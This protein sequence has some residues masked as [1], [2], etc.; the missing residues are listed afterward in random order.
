MSLSSSQLFLTK[1]CFFK[2]VVYMGQIGCRKNVRG[3]LMRQPRGVLFVWCGTKGQHGKAAERPIP[4][5]YPRT[6]VVESPMS[7]TNGAIYSLWMVGKGGMV[8]LPTLL[9]Y[10]DVFSAKEVFGTVLLRLIQCS[11]GTAKKSLTTIVFVF[12]DYLYRVHKRDRCYLW[13]K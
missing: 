2:P 8:L 12:A 9:Q 10:R 5:G 13:L 3:A 6:R 11:I 1:A 4:R 7:A